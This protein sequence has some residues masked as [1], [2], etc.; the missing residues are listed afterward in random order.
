MVPDTIRHGIIKDLQKTKKKIFHL[1]LLLKFPINQLKISIGYGSIFIETPFSLDRFEFQRY[2]GSSSPSSF[3]SELTLND[4]NYKKKYRIMY[5][6]I[7]GI[8]FFNTVMILRVHI[9][10]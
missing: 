8:D 6:L 7:K 4:G 1:L 2:P 3:A 5:F 10:Q 9:F